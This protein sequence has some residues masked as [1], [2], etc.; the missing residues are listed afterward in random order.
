MAAT[1]N[2]APESKPEYPMPVG[3]RTLREEI[4]RMFQAFSLPEMNWRS[5]LA[6]LTDDVVGLRVDV[7]ETDSEIQVTTEL[8]GIDEDA[9]DVSL[10]GDLLRIRAEKRSEQENDDKKW[11]V[12]ERT[13]GTFERTVRVP[14]GIDPGS[15]RA[16]FSKGVLT[17]SLPKPPTASAEAKKIAITAG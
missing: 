9:I 11:H 14:T 16:E 8:P 15:V 7:S 17:V 13:Y 1:E 10:V 3:F 5:G 2:E 6:G 12:V 4:D